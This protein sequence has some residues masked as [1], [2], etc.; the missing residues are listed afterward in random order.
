MKRILLFTFA[1][2]FL[3]NLFS[4]TTFTGPIPKITSGYGSPGPYTPETKNFEVQFNWEKYYTDAVTLASIT[5]PKELGEKAPIVF[6]IPW[7]SDSRL[8]ENTFYSINKERAE[9]IASQGYCYVTLQYNSPG[10]LNESNKFGLCKATLDQLVDSF[11]QYIDTTRIGIIGSFM[12][13]GARAIQ[14]ASEKFIYQNWGENGRFL[15]TD[16]TGP[17]IVGGDWEYEKPVFTNEALDAFP[18]DMKY[19]TILGDLTHWNDPSFAIDFY[20]HIGVPDS[21]KAFFEI[22]TDT[23]DGYIYFGGEVMVMTNTQFVNDTWA[24][25]VKYDAY[26]EYV[27]YRTIDALGNLLWRNDYEARKYCLG[28]DES[29]NIPMADGQLKPIHNTDDPDP[30]IYWYAKARGSY[31]NPCWAVPWNQRKYYIAWPCH[32]FMEK[33]ELIQG[34]FKLFP[35]PVENKTKLFFD[36]Q[37]KDQILSIEIFNPI[38]QLLRKTSNININEIDLTDIPQAEY[39]LIR[40]MFKYN[41]ETV[42]EIIKID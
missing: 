22:P 33:T 11:S 37:W 7:D 14:V 12:G 26:D 13:G 1:I 5:Y 4:Q 38:G 31:V 18:D 24:K 35:N 39:L 41:N 34:E 42:T 19:I 27:Y 3:N 32:G 17:S 10:E 15:I 25:Y 8:T 2:I 40:I 9:R 30:N 23:I 21:N 29:G 36:E 6:F 16:H 28:E 20:Q